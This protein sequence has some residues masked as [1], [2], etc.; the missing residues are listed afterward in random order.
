[1]IPMN[2][3]VIF[4]YLLK[5]HEYKLTSISFYKTNLSVEC[6]IEIMKFFDMERKIGI[7]Q[8]TKGLYALELEYNEIGPMKMDILR[9]C[10]VEN[11]PHKG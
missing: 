11:L 9:N 1:M 7:W 2:I 10:F 5:L 6:M 4:N 8:T 3:K